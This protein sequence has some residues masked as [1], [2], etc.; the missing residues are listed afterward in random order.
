MRHFEDYQRTKSNPYI[1]PE[2]LYKQ[3]LYQIRDYN[4]I[5]EEIKDLPTRSPAPPDGQPRGNGTGNPTEYTGVKLAQYK[6]IKEAI[7]KA[8]NDIPVEYREGVWKKV[9][10]NSNYPIDAD[11][12]TYWRYKC[13]FVYSVAKYLFLA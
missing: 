10:Y 7:E 13:K 6:T 8:R 12:S 3:T 1:L 9:M 4:R 2:N 11:P 5:C